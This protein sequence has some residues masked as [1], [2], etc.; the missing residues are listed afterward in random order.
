MKTIKRCQNC[1]HYHALKVSSDTDAKPIHLCKL[2]PDCRSLS[3]IERDDDDARHDADRGEYLGTFCG[4]MRKPG[5]MCGPLA[6]MWS[7]R[8][9]YMDVV[10][11]LEALAREKFDRMYPP[12]TM[13]RTVVLNKGDIAAGRY[14]PLTRQIAERYGK[15]IAVTRRHLV[16][17]IS[18]GWVLADGR[19]GTG[20]IRW[21]P[22]GLA[23]KLQ[24]ELA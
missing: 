3:V 9:R 16:Q 11:V 18:Y 6:A 21:W 1:I 7:K 14:G 4:V 12:A 19:G 20:G 5:A 17:A 22:S 13:Q 24:G 10:P 23:A 15:S 8:P 2:P